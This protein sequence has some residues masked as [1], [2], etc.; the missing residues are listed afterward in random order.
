MYWLDVYSP[1]AYEDSKGIEFGVTG[2]PEAREKAVQRISP[3]DILICYMKDKSL[4]FGALEVTSKPYYDAKKVIWREK[5]CP[6]RI[7]VRP[8]IIREPEKA[9][10]ARTLLSRLKLFANLKNPANW[11]PTLRTSPRLLDEDDGKLILEELNKRS[12]G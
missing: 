12:L 3:D 10:P 9:I 8:V 6:H 1:R 7:Q 11:G 4:W 2:F 5:L